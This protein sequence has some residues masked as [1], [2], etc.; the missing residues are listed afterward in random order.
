MLLHYVR[1]VVHENFVTRIRICLRVVVGRC[2]GPAAGVERARHRKLPAPRPVRRDRWHSVEQLMTTVQPLLAS[3]SSSPSSIPS[4]AAARR[5]SPT[6]AIVVER[7]RGF[8]GDRGPRRPPVIFYLRSL[9][10]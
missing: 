5:S 1:E 9:F 3:A 2:G 4:E 10:F 7:T 6:M 8:R